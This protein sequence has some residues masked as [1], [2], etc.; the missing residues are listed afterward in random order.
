M[1]TINYVEH[2]ASLW[3][4]PPHADRQFPEARPLL[5]HYCSIATLE[6]IVRNEQMWLS[7]P[8]YMNDYE[9]LRF[10]LVHSRD[11][12]HN[13]DGIKAAIGQGERYEVLRKHF[14][15]IYEQFES[16]LSFDIYIAC[17]SEHDPLDNDGLLSMWRGYGANGSGAAIVFD[18][19]V[20]AE[21]PD[22][23][24]RI[25]R[26]TYG[27]TADR[28]RWINEILDRFASLLS[29]RLPTDELGACAAHLFERLLAFSVYTKHAGFK[30]ENEWRVV[31][32]KHQDVRNRLVGMLDYHVSGSVVEPKLKYKIGP[33]DGVAAEGVNLEKLTAKIILGPTGASSLWKMAVQRMLDKLGH[34]TIGQRIVAS[35]TPYRAR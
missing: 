27:T 2:F 34:S 17:F 1:S 30:E 28:I 20:F 33:L 25:A 22:S 18:T 11:R 14:N 3:N 35:S 8:L 12:F 24:L 21:V 7:N 19:S 6:A 4:L 32:F 10:G 15:G 29:P 31:Y 26:V 13:H 16:G 9:E 23:P 5:A